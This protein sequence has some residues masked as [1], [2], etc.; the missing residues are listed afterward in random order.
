MPGALHNL[1]PR[2]KRVSAQLR[3]WNLRL[4]EQRMREAVARGRIGFH[5][6][7]LIL[8]G[9]EQ[10]RSHCWRHLCCHTWRSRIT[11]TAS[12]CLLLPFVPML[13]M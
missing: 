3:A 11:W 8:E 13:P 9:L 10:V 1:G 4:G 7:L 6:A 5:D 2:E 12:A